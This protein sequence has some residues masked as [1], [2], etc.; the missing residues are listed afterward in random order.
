MAETA[1]T[2]EI[3]TDVDPRY[4]SILERFKTIPAGR[5]CVVVFIDSPDRWR[6][7]NQIV[8][9]PLDQR[10]PVRQCRRF[11]IG[12][13]EAHQH[14]PIDCA[15]RIGGVVC[16]TRDASCTRIPAPPVADSLCPAPWETT[17][18]VELEWEHRAFLWLVK[19]SLTVVGCLW[20]WEYWFPFWRVR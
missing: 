17:M 5:I 9:Q 2:A 11:Y 6:Q 14:E 16:G 7:A 8:I 18:K 3:P 1:E 4:S 19:A 20:L 10:I 13:G 12:A 15:V